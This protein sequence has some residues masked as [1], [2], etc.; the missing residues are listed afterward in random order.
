MALSRRRPA[1]A[2][3]EGGLP[4]LRQLLWGCFRHLLFG[5][6]IGSTI[7]RLHFALQLHSTTTLRSRVII[8]ILLLPAMT[9]L[10]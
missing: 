6:Q 8:K 3:E 10:T 1:E 5:L 4:S 7:P 9:T 2:A